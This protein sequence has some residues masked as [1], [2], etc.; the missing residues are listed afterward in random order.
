MPSAEA[1]DKRGKWLRNGA[2]LL[3]AT[4][5]VSVP[6]PSRPRRCCWVGAG[7]G[8]RRGGGDGAELPSPSEH[9]KIAFH[10]RAD[11]DTNPSTVRRALGEEI[12]F[13]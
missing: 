5:A 1:A 4:S 13:D 12:R 10:G 11:W 9:W 2:C 8:G 7:M 6:G 3:G